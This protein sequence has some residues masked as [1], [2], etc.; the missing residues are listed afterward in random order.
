MNKVFS[1]FLA[2]TREHEWGCDESYNLTLSNGTKLSVWDSGVL[3]VSPA[4][5]G[6]KDVV[7]SC[8]V[9]GNETG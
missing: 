2:W 6:H 8:A 1:D 5:P 9:H 7:L 3:E 4:S